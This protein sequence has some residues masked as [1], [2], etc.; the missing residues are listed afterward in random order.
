M[1]DVIKKIIDIETKAQQIID[2]AEKEKIDQSN[3]LKEKLKNLKI[4][5]TQDAHNKVAFLREKEISETKQIASEKANECTYKL[6][7]IQ[8][9]FDEYGE[10]WSDSLVTSVLKR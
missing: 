3:E 2:A 8:K 1:D 9:I 5:L 7:A 10:Q 4:K 6:E